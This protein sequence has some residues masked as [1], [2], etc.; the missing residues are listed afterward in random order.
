MIWIGKFE[1]YAISLALEGASA[2]RPIT[3]D[4]LN[5]VV[6]K[7]GGNVERILIDDL[8][9]DTYY[10]KVTIAYDSKSLDIDSRPSD[11]IALGLRAK[12]PM[13]MVEG[14]LEKASVQE[15]P[16]S[17]PVASSPNTRSTPR[18]PSGSASTSRSRS[19]R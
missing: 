11:A 19:I 8:W 4:L 9:N 5:N 13:Y 2:D 16:S 10:A 15:E 7:M 14:V 18:K 6:N 17:A 12:A 1:A 3:H